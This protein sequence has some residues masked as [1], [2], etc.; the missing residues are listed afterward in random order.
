MDTL[1]QACDFIRSL[2]ASREKA[3]S[4]IYHLPRRKR[5]LVGLGLHRLVRCGVD[6]V[7]VSGSEGNR[8]HPLAASPVRQICELLDPAHPAF[9]L[10]GGD[11]GRDARDPALPL[12][13]CVQPKSE[14]SFADYGS[15]PAPAQAL[16]A[17]RAG[18][19]QTVPDGEFLARLAWA[20]GVLR[21]QARDQPGKMII[22]RPY[23]KAV[24]ARDRLDLFQRFAASEPAAAAS[25]F[26]ELG[27]GFHSLGCSPENIFEV[28]DGRLSFDVVAATRGISPDP[29]TDR[30]WL[31]ALR[32]DPKERREHL[33]AFERYQA[34][35]QRLTEPGSVQVERKLDVLQLGNVRHL[36]SRL[37]GRLRPG[38]DWSGLLEESYPALVSYPPQL[39]RLADSHG[40]PNRFYGG[41]LGRVAPGGRQAEF[42]LNLRAALINV[43]TL[44]TLGGV[45]VIAE[46]E[47]EKELLEVNNK[48]SGLMKAIAAWEGQR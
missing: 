23:Q 36:Y 25:H 5:S 27:A 4:Y 12:A 18:G 22:T 2:G 32:T 24:D 13:V 9:L 14:V 33:M 42:F 1:K 38:V 34:R 47:P 16:P 3:P 15:D 28:D 48:L 45:G 8:L 31:E 37:S 46:S 20:I 11:I 29:E 7:Q 6:G 21:E 26:L 39:H 30:R 40:L 35:L 10:I 17:E 19:W 43:D 41:I 44:Y